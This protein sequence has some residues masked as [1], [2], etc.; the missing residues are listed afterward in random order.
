MVHDPA[1]F[2]PE[3]TFSRGELERLQLER[4]QALVAR[5]KE[6]V[7]FYRERLRATPVPRSLAELA[8]LPFTQK[9]DFRDTYPL[10]LLAVSER[11]LRRV[12]ASSGTTGNPTIGAYTTGDLRVFGEG[13]ARSLAGGGI[14][15]REP[16]LVD[17][18]TVRIL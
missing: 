4:L 10:G 5:L 17:R 13:M 2:S 14:R 1:L 3:E 16:L 8:T 7:P 11:E 18:L 15:P 12:H 6:R 9:A